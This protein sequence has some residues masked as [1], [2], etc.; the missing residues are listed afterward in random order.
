MN[1]QLLLWNGLSPIN[2][3]RV[4]DFSMM[5]R[6]GSSETSL[7]YVDYLYEE[8]VR[9]YS[10][11]DVKIHP[12]YKRVKARFDVAM[13]TLEEAVMWS[14]SIFPVCLPSVQDTKNPLNHYAGDTVTLAGWG[15]TDPNNADNVSPKLLQANFKIRNQE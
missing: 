12:Q 5:A 13:V 8:G 11:V 14:G 3:C 1:I 10:I 2:A 7:D 4:Y 15:S 9:D 6:L